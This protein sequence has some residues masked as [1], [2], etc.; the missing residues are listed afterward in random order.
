MA[1]IARHGQLGP[2]ISARRHPTV[3]Q[4]A[5]VC[6]T[7]ARK[8]YTHRGGT[9]TVNRETQLAGPRRVPPARIG[10]AVGVGL[11]LH[12]SW[13]GARSATH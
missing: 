10:V 9:T 12:S 1:R 7:D 8:I 3:S 2:S 11:A 4:R 13:P 5:A 6:R